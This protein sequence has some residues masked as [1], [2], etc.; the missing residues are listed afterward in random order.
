MDG[1]INVHGWD[2][3]MN[4]KVSE[5]KYFNLIINCKNLDKCLI[6]IIIGVGYGRCSCDMNL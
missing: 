5:I 6:V 1:K 3:S 4:N 2:S